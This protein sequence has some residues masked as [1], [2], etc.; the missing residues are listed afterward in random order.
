VV[1]WLVAFE[2]AFV[3][4]LVSFKTARRRTSELT[5]KASA[6]VRSHLDD[7]PAW[8]NMSCEE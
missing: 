2:A 8:G 6:S 1:L 3:V 4:D 7:M 5:C